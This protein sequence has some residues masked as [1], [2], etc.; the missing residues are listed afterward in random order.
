M[1]RARPRHLRRKSVFSQP[2]HW[3]GAAKARPFGGKPPRRTVQ[4]ALYES[5]L[6][7]NMANM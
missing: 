3:S 2:R 7:K 6:R 1:S 5:L 4:L